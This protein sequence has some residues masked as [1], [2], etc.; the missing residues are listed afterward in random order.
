MGMTRERRRFNRFAAT[1]TIFPRFDATY[2]KVVA[3]GVLALA[4]FAPSPSRAQTLS[5]GQAAQFGA[6][7]VSGDSG[8]MSVES[9]TISGSVGFGVGTYYAIDSSSI[10]GTLYNAAGSSNGGLS[11]TT[12]AGGIVTGTQAV[13]VIAG[14]TTDAVDA[15]HAAAH[16][17]H[18]NNAITISG[19]S[20]TF[21]GNNQFNVVN[22]LSL[23]LNNGTLTINGNGSPNA[24]FL[25]NFSGALSLSNEQIVLNGISASNV[26]FNSV[27]GSVSISE[28]TIAGQILDL[29]GTAVSL[30]DD[31]NVNGSVI[32][33][34]DLTINNPSVVTPELPTG[35]MA[36]LASV[37]FFCS[38]GLNWRRRLSRQ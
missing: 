15:S 36:A 11:N 10:G 7:E 18:S 3:V 2:F 21:T 4:A 37:V 32:A 30:V 29:N 1:W 6:L 9:T 25:F 5:L 20:Y 14:A 35:M 38:A 13:N 33:N 12:A 17:Y 28:S 19:D 31:G 34:G 24:Q 23:S 8:V 27:G 16:Y 22:L 26:F